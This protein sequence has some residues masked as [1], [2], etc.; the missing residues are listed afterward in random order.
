MKRDVRGAEDTVHSK[1]HLWP[2]DHGIH[3]RRKVELVLL[4]GN[5]HY[6]VLVDVIKTLMC[7]DDWSSLRETGS[8][9]PTTLVNAGRPWTVRT[10]ANEDAVI[11]A[12]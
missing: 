3:T 2:N 6:V 7:F 11:A 1:A 4:Q 8:V 5:T 12:V 10:P 9:T